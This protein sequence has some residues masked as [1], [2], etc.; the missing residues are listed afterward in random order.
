M[1]ARF[2]K[3]VMNNKRSHNWKNARNEQ[4]AQNGALTVWFDGSAWPR[5]ICHSTKTNI[6][7]AG[8]TRVLRSRTSICI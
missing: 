2:Q 1:V 4:K 3:L 6:R 7:W 5:F 8:Q